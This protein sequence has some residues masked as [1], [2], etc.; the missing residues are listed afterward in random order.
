MEGYRPNPLQTTGDLAEAA[1]NVK[2]GL[3]IVCHQLH[4]WWQIKKTAFFR[5]TLATQ[6]KRFSVALERFAGLCS[7]NPKRKRGSSLALRVG[8]TLHG[9]ETRSSHSVD[10]PMAHDQ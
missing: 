2:G 5:Q 8:K 10:C 4:G 7:T 9:H 3:T 1:K 6:I